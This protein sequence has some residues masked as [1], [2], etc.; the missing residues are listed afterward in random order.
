[1]PAEA[2]DYSAE[3]SRN[4]N[5]EDKIFAPH[6]HDFQVSPA[7]AFT[8]LQMYPRW[9][10]RLGGLDWLQDEDPKA[11]YMTCTSSVP[12]CGS[13]GD[14]PLDPRGVRGAAS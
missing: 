13:L 14:L 2:K 4:V 6:V 7:I 8:R 5:F 11:I 3:A 1:M 12:K 10:A 9:V